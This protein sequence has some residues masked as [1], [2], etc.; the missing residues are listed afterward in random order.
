M[1]MEAF[2]QEWRRRVLNFA[3]SWFSVN[4]GTG[5][6]SILLFNLPYQFSGLHIIADVIFALN[7][8]LFVLFLMTSM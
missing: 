6:T 1:S 2:K 3:P 7:V 5:I 8:V 4:M